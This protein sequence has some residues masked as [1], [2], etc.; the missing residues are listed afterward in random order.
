MNI[1]KCRIHPVKPETCVAGPITF[2]INKKTGKIEWHLK[3]EKIC[4]LAGNMFKNE[5]ALRKHL[6]SAKTEIIRL[7]HQLDPKALQIIL[8]IDEPHTFKVGEDNIDKEILDKLTCD[9]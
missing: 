9:S 2:D 1:R 3:K 6:E 7:V 8:K 5:K 4:S